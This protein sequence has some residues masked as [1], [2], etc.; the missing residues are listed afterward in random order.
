MDKNRRTNLG[1][2][3]CNPVQNRHQQEDGHFRKLTGD[4]LALA[5]FRAKLEVCVV[6]PP[7]PACHVGIQGRHKED[8][9][10]YVQ[11]PNGGGMLDARLHLCA[12]FFAH[13][14]EGGEEIDVQ[15]ERE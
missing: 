11:R 1:N 9:P 3:G 15:G 4:A 14:D 10:K 6:I 7:A 2:Q 5:D 8:V 13:L 12:M